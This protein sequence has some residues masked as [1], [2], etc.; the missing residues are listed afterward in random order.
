M[1]L[2]GFWHAA[3]AAAL[4]TVEDQPSLLMVTVQRRRTERDFQTAPE[5]QNTYSSTS[6]KL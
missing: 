3:S 1:K 2:V 6:D 4:H 5:M